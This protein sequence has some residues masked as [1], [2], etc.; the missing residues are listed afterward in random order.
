MQLCIRTSSSDSG[1]I[2]ISDFRYLYELARCSKCQMFI[3]KDNILYGASDESA[4]I[5]EI[6]VP[7]QTNTDLMFR[8]DTVP[9]DIF[10]QHN[11]FFIPKDFDWVILPAY[12]WDM[13]MAGDLEALYSQDID[14]YIVLDKTTKIPIQQIFINKYRFV[15]DFSRKKMINQLDAYFNRLKTLL[16][17]YEFKDVQNHPVVRY[18]FDS[19]SI[20]G[21]SVVHLYDNNVNIAFYLFKGMFSL[22]KSDTLNIDIRFDAFSTNLFVASFKPIRKKNPMTIKTYGVPFSEQIHCMY[23]NLV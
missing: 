15:N 11:S 10:D 23:I 17:K 21:E 5:H 3:L 1:M 4:A 20:A 12:Y 13:Y 7:Y 2:P 16:P 14:Q 8:V 9:K 19:K 22:G 18:I 6:P